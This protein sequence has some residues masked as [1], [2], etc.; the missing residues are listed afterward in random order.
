[1]G[2]TKHTEPFRVVVDTEWPRTSNGS[3][4]AYYHEFYD[5]AQARYMKL[6]IDQV[7]ETRLITHIS[8]E[9]YNE[10]LG[11]YVPMFESLCNQSIESHGLN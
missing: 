10:H 3:H 8:F 5:A 7:M 4:N 2:R 9:R 11:K 1:M 6:L